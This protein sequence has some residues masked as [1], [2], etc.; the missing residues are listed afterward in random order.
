MRVHLTTLRAGITRTPEFEKKGLAQ[1][2]VNAW[3][4]PERILATHFAD[5]IT[6]LS[7]NC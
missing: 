4:A 6:G 3:G 2:A 5:Q 1:F 7:W